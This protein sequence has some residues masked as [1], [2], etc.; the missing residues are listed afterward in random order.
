VQARYPSLRIAESG[1]ASI[2]Q[3]VNNALTFGKAEATSGC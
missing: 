3:A 2:Q 1:D